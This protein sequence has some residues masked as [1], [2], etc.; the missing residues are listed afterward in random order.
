MLVVDASV[1]VKAIVMEEGSQTALQIT[2]RA[3]L[4]VPAHC[5]AEVGETL[6]RKI[7]SGQVRADQVERIMPTLVD[8]FEQVP[9][10]RLLIRAMN[11]S[12]ATGASVYDCLYVA[13]A[14]AENCRLVTADRRLIEKMA[15]T[16]HAGLLAPLDSFT[17]SP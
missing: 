9:L 4:Y 1:L 12:L 5:F 7:R 8:T 14:A 2:R 13:L 16:E 15:G 6:A 17:G 11:I 3:D 10:G